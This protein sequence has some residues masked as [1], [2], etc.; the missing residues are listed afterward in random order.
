MYL[1]IFYLNISAATAAN[2]DG[3]TH[4]HSCS[5]CRSNTGELEF[6]L[7]CLLCFAFWVFC[8]LT[9]V[10]LYLFSCVFFGRLRHKRVCFE[11]VSR[12]IKFNMPHISRVLNVLLRFHGSLNC[13]FLGRLKISPTLGMHLF[14][15]ADARKAGCRLAAAAT[16]RCT[17]PMF[18]F[19]FL[20]ALSY[21]RHFFITVL[22]W[23]NSVDIFLAAWVFFPI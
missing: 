2:P 18:I 19:I 8:F 23:T 4:E 7:L 14:F 6:G 13:L 15:R 17:A 5:R 20:A 21:W 9:A 10:C 11:L 3:N 1:C 12:L 16:S 22:E